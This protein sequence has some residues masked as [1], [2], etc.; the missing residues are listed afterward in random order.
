MSAY[1][2][3]RN[4]TEKRS[5]LWIF[6][7]INTIRKNIIQRAGRMAKPQGKLKLIMSANKKIQDEILHYFDVLAGPV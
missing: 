2:K 1:E 4:T 6:K 3:Q 5:S 7:E